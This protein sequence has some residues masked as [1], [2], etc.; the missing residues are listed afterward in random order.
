MVSV[1]VVEDDPMVMDI[2]CK[3]IELIEGFNVC[4][5]AFDGASALRLLEDVKTDLLVLDIYMPVMNGVELLKRVREKQIKVDAMFLT[6]D[7][8]I[9][10]INGALKLGGVDYLIKPFSY[11]R[12]KE[13][14]EHYAARYRLLS[15]K[16]RTTQEEI[17]AFIKYYPPQ[18][19]GVHKGIHRATLTSIRGYICGRGR[20]VITQ[21]EISQMLGLSKVT[22]RRYMEYLVSTNEVCLHI[23]YGAVGRPAHTY[24]KLI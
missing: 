21:D 2:T 14:F 20:D 6:A 1:M 23:E 24:K 19:A 3:Y 13:A 18:G 10:R 4:A 12:F 7:S 17:D 9:S 22:V 16:G 11:E 15:G 5:K 8:N